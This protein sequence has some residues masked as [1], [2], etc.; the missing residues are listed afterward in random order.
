MKLLDKTPA[1]LFDI[2]GH[3][4][5]QCT[6]E[7][8]KKVRQVKEDE[9]RANCANGAPLAR[10]LAAYDIIFARKVLTLIWQIRKDE[11]IMIDRDWRKNVSVDQ[12]EGLFPRSGYCED[13]FA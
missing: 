4:D 1:S 7:G 8:Y 3:L 11:S 12:L 6:I 5:E 9:H 10:P 13:R 2:D